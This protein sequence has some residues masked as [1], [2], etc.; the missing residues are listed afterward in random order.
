[1]GEQPNLLPLAGSL[2]NVEVHGLAAL[3]SHPRLT[4]QAPVRLVFAWAKSDD[5]PIIWGQVNFF[6]EFNACFYRSQHVF[7]LTPS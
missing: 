4:P 6:M 7:D 5:V 1:L 2:R 3:A